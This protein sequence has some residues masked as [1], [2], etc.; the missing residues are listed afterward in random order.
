MDINNNITEITPKDSIAPVYLI[1]FSQ[2]ELDEI[3]AYAK[4]YERYKN[5]ID[6]PEKS[7]E[8]YSAIKKLQ[9]LG[10]TEEE[11]RSIAGV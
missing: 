4:E 9:K 8:F 1:P 11:A 6:N 7:P 5:T 10:L 2:D 3:S